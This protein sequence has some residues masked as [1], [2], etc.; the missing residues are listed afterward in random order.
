MLTLSSSFTADK[1]ATLITTPDGINSYI[2][3]H[4]SNTRLSINCFWLN[5]D[6]AIFRD[7]QLMERLKY[8]CLSNTRVQ[9][10]FLVRNPKQVIGRAT[11][12][13]PLLHRFTTNMRFKE[14]ARD[15]DEE[16]AHFITFD[17]QG[18]LY[19]PNF[20]HCRC[21]S[22][23]HNPHKSKIL[24]GY[25]EKAWELSQDTAEFRPLHL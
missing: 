24:T 1:D 13:T 3:K 18:Y 9:L 16:V 23:Q 14:L 22:Q 11:Y 10:R 5:L 20:E 7:M 8:L 2:K 21:F 19:Q 15:F 4:L 6:N 25:F 12:L 17:D